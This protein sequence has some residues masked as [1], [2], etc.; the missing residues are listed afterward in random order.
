MSKGDRGIEMTRRSLGKLVGSAATA[1]AAAAAG[2]VFIPQS[3]VA[4][5]TTL[6]ASDVSL[7]SNAGQLQT[8]T[9]Q[10]DIDYEWNGLDS[11]PQRIDFYV[12]A[13]LPDASGGATTFEQIGTEGT[14]ISSSALESSSSKSYS[15]QSAVSILGH[16]AIDDK[17]FEKNGEGWTKETTVDIQVRTVLTD[18][19]STTYSDTPQASFTVTLTNETGGVNSGG[20]AN[21]SGSAK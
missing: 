2:I 10:P 3:A 21:P 9:V 7:S 4:A 18:T 20:N 6:S 11:S 1:G 14:T 13:R 12:E 17:D 15:F 16:S 8:L 5:T 19:D